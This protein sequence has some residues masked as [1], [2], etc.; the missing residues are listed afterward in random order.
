MKKEFFSKPDG[1]IEHWPGELSSFSWQDFV[2]AIPSPL[3]VVTSWKSNGKE[4]ACLQSWSSFV[5]SSGEFICIIASVT[6]GGHMHQSLKETGCCVLNF[7]SKDIIDKCKKTIDNNEFDVDEITVSGLTSEKAISVNAPRI[8]ECFLNIECELLWEREHFK[9]SRH[10]VVALKA[11]HLCMDSERYDENKL[12]RY[13]K[14]GFMYNI[15][16]PRNPDT[17]EEQQEGAF[18]ALKLYN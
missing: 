13:G 17:G 5:G 10:T 18:G 15:N 1:I 6:K 14:T 3:F 9:N 7:P 16:S 2:T 11:V 4:N 8:V 12:G